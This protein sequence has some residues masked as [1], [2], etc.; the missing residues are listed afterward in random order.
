MA[1]KVPATLLWSAEDQQYF[2][3]Q[4]G[5]T[6]K[7][8]GVSSE[9]RVFRLLDEAISFS[10]HGQQGRLNLQKQTRA[11][12][13]DGYWYAYRRQ[14]KRVVKK[15][16]GRPA[17]LT[18]A[19][20]EELALAIQA[21][22]IQRESVQLP[23]ASHPSPSLPPQTAPSAL[24]SQAPLLLP[25][26]RPPRPTAS[27]LSRRRLLERLD[28]GLSRKLT[29]L[30][31]PAGYGKTTLVSEWIAAR[32]TRDGS[33]PLVAWIALDEGD[34]DPIRFW[35]YLI[36][37]CQTFQP[38]LGESLLSQLGAAEPLSFSRPS[39]EP[40]LTGL[41]NDLASM[42]GCGI[43]MLEDYHMIHSKEIHQALSF[44][45]EHQPPNL[46]L[47]LLTRREPPLPLAQLRA[48]DDLVELEASHLRFT[49]EETRVFLRQTLPFP[50]E[51][52]LLEQVQQRTE[53]WITGLRLL[54]LALQSQGSL[55]AREME[56]R[57]AQI[58][59]RDRSILD[60]LV[61]EVLASQAE[62]LQTFL[63]ETTG[64]VRLS[65]SLCDTV[66][67]RD[68]SMFVLEQI[69]RAHLFLL[70]L[71][72]SGT[73][74]R[75]HALF[76]EA[77]QHEARRRLGEA[78]LLATQSRA[79]RWYEQH[80]LLS[81]AVEAALSA[82]ELQRAA[83]LLTRIVESQSLW[84]QQEVHIFLRWL[85]QFPEEILRESPTLSQTYAVALLHCEQQCTSA[86]RPQLEKY[87]QMAEQRLQALGDLPRLGEALALHALLIRHMNDHATAIRCATSALKL[88]PDEERFW[89]SLALD[90]LSMASLVAGRITEARQLMHEARKLNPVSFEENSYARRGSLIQQGYLALGAGHLEQAA[91]LM[92]RVLDTAGNDRADRGTALIGLSTLSYEWNRLWEAEQYIQQAYA[93]H[94]ETGNELLWLQSAQLL[95]RVL[96]A[97]GEHTQAQELLQRLSSALAQPRYSR[98]IE[99]WLAH[100]ALASG[101]LVTAQRRLAG[102]HIIAQNE[103]PLDIV[104]E[105]EQLLTARLLIAQ[106][107]EGKVY[108][109]LSLLAGRRA[110]AQS[111]ARLR[112]E[113]EVLLIM[114]RAYAYLRR[115]QEVQEVLKEALALAQTAGYQ[116]L[117]FDEGAEMAAL[118]KGMVSE[119]R[120]PLQ[121]AFVRT[122]LRGFTTVRLSTIP[123]TGYDVLELLSSGERRVLH[124]LVAGRTNPEIARELVVSLNT[125]KTQVKSIYRKLGI[126]SRHEA[127]EVAR[128]LGLL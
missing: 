100:F 64:L 21:D 3:Q 13:V 102:L 90:M 4:E 60:Y 124:L 68:D 82:R 35:R 83:Q 80:D 47:I 94:A 69:E 27:L 77:M 113:V 51:E 93:L 104:R 36:V 106:G 8:V 2:W 50:C 84:H 39:L 79:S 89:R 87:L 76:A 20:L 115:K 15:Y 9:A 43:L 67:G 88:L 75:Y 110:E 125:V 49:P 6:Q 91:L 101:D 120:A 61:A 12:G 78:R 107:E 22:P 103:P 38:N 26:L 63:L 95:A 32:D 11:R 40:I 5:N 52:T 114:A 54:T 56:Q 66:T 86:L 48:H 121:V 116:R 14:G 99:L 31:A 34:N 72:E 28:E 123:A 96:Y 29:L 111:Q 30:L 59:G 112:S 105:Q 19:R 108:Q 127:S 70:P 92:R 57:L 119:M 33:S 55:S 25:K 45:L 16:A 85:R 109:A 44:F 118:L 73:W 117:F 98:E 24:L 46:H 74:Y 7:R 10:F 53:G 122:L 62:P 1:K 81:D 23:S 71:D 128:R 97:R 17:D 65:G 58:S 18:I 42:P 126:G 37:A 41:L